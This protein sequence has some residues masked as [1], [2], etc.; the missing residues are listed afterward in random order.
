MV[1]PV[2]KT[3]RLEHQSILPHAQ[4]KTLQ[5]VTCGNVHA[6]DEGLSSKQMERGAIGLAAGLSVDAKTPV[7]G[8]NKIVIGSQLMPAESSEGG[9]TIDWSSSARVPQLAWRAVSAADCG[10]QA[11]GALFKARH[12]QLHHQVQACL[13]PQHVGAH[14]HHH[15]RIR[16]HI[17]T[18]ADRLL[19]CAAP[20][21]RGG[22]WQQSPGAG[23]GT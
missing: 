7:T 14:V 12:Q 17:C 4:V 6:I 3:W 23:G 19:L 9:A 10:R 2:G 5:I 13:V 21:G 8:V 1:P 20:R 22:E 18:P 16:S 15:H 11:A